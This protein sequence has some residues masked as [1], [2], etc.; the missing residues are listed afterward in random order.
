MPRASEIT[1]ATR[2]S[3]ILSFQSLS[4]ARTN[5]QATAKKATINRQ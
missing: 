4:Q 1:P 5:I 3:M 2:Y